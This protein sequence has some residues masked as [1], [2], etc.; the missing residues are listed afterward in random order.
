[1]GVLN[2]IRIEGEGSI[3]ERG[4]PCRVYVALILE[5][6]SRSNYRQAGANRSVSTGPLSGHRL[7]GALFAAT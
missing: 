1:M 7:G 5:G 3:P 2:D 6:C 4:M